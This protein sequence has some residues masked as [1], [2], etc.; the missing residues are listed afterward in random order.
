MMKPGKAFEKW[1]ARST[2][3]AAIRVEATVQP[4][5]VE[6]HLKLAWEAGRRYGK[7]EGVA[8]ELRRWRRVRDDGT[9]IPN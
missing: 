2:S 4:C 3:R 6:Y 8:E 5:V 9:H 1:F 7:E